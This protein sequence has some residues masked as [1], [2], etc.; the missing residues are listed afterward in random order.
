MH[1]CTRAACGTG[2]DEALHLD[3]RT[4]VESEPT[5]PFHDAILGPDHKC[6]RREKK[7]SAGK[8]LVQRQ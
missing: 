8:E 4:K 2:Q 1:A 5:G 7:T 3:T 6:Q